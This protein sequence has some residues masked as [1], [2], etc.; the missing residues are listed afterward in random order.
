MTEFVEMILAQLIGNIATALILV[1]IYFNFLLFENYL[2]LIVWAILCSQ[3]LRQA[4]NNVI[5]VLQY[6]STDADISRYG[7]LTCVFS[8]SAEIFISHPH[9]RSRRTAKELFLNYGIFL[10]SLIGAVSIWMRMYSWVSFLNVIIGFSI[11]ALSLMKLL[12][13]RIFYYRYFFSDEVLVSVVLILGFFITG[14]FVI[15]FL[16]TESYLEGSRAATNLSEWVQD[17][18]INDERARQVWSEQVENSRAMISQAI[19]GIEDNFN[20]TMWWP[21]LKSLVKTYYVDAKTSDGNST[22]HASLFS[23]LRLPENMTLVQVATFAYSK[24]ESVNLTSVQLTDWTSKGLEVSSIAVGSVAQLVFLAFTLVIAFVSLGVRS[25]F[26]ISSLFYLLCTNWDPIERASSFLPLKMASIHAIVTMISFTIVNADFMYLATTVTFFISIVPIISPFLVCVPWV[27]SIGLTS[28][29]VKALAL[30]AVQY[31]AFTVLDEMLYEKSIVAVN[32][33]VSALSVVFGV[34]VFGFEGVIFGPLIVCGVTFAYDVSN[35]GIQ[36]AQDE[37]GKSEEVKRDD[38][39]GGSDGE[40]SHSTTS[41][42]DSSDHEKHKKL[43]DHFEEDVDGEVNTNIFSNAVYRVISGPLVDR[44]RRRLSIDVAT[45]GSVCVTLIVEGL[46]RVRKVRFVVNKSWTQPALLD[47]ICRMLRVHSIEYIGTEDGIEV[48]SP[49]HIKADEVLHVKVRSR[50]RLHMYSDSHAESRGRLSFSVQTP[51]TSPNGIRASALS[52][53]QS[54]SRDGSTKKVSSGTLSRAKLKRMGSSSATVGNTPGAKAVQRQVRVQRRDEGVGIRLQEG[55]KR[56]GSYDETVLSTR[57][58][59]APCDS[60]RRST[61]SSP[62][63][64]NAANESSLSSL[65]A[66]RLSSSTS[67]LAYG[68]ELLLSNDDVFMA[69]VETSS[70]GRMNDAEVFAEISCT[71]AVLSPATTSSAKEGK[72]KLHVADLT[73]SGDFPTFSASHDASGLHSGLGNDNSADAVDKAAIGTRPNGGPL[74]QAKHRDLLKVVHLGA[75]LIVSP[76]AVGSNA[77][78]IGSYSS[79]EDNGSEG[80]EEDK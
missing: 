22:S 69:E 24:V 55:T 20:D 43:G 47:N 29:I 27:I 33:Y 54:G 79:S 44:V 39:L 31:V 18:F 14:T 37:G 59:I 51:S 12:D 64:E 17:N 35:H 8:K 38:S 73:D 34:Y 9:D 2:R 67:P 57:G 58:D 66:L 6:L 25:F 45:E 71:A 36:A 72:P 10:F 26:F 74:T 40:G 1:L 76:L 41:S 21:P 78:R 7:F 80:Q 16:G 5:S 68:D 70:R 48:L 23:S 65:T 28:S 50:R 61:S 42:L 63:R 30:F 32:S 46:K 19:C 52:L 3:A 15:V 11:A 53:S 13:R 60:A 49:L 75:T 4:K 62:S 56:R 77:A